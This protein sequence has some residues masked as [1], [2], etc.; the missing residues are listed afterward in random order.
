M[1]LVGSLNFEHRCVTNEGTFCKS[2][3]A[4]TCSFFASD[5]NKSW[6]LENLTEE[7]LALSPGL[8]K[9][10][11]ECNDA[12]TTNENCI[13]KCSDSDGGWQV[14]KVD[15]ISIQLSTCEN[16]FVSIE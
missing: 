6:V 8:H 12:T 16:A 2:N 5:E 10:Y 3:Q 4:L 15:S 13:L 14:H 11:N 1:D 9:A 7:I